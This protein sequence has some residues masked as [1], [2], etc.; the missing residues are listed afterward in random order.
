MLQKLKENK[1]L[2]FLLKALLLYILWYVLYDLWLNPYGN[3]DEWVINNLVELSS[4]V[5]KNIMGY[6][7]MPEPLLAENIRTVGIDGTHGLWIG[8]PCNG[9]TL[10]ALFTGFVI[11][12]PGPVKRKLWF[13]PMG[14]LTIHLLNVIRIVCLSLIVK[15]APEYLKFNHTYTFTFLVYSY[16]FI[17]WM[18]WANRY[19]QTEVQGE[20]H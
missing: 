6:R 14:I 13:I 9:L 2:F 8:D 18:L 4:F 17:L 11:A 1:V 12:Y 15:Y 16:V 20:K 10:F 5:L 19:S 7:L 3:I